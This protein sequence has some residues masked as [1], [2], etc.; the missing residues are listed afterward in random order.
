MAQ[1]N[2][3]Y[4]NGKH[5]EEKTK[6]DGSSIPPL[7]SRKG[8]TQKDPTPIE[9]GVTKPPMLRQPSYQDKLNYKA[10]LYSKPTDENNHEA[11]I[12]I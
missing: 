9:K 6:G 3:T 12:E 2:Y 8:Y 1:K 11:S 5:E 10:D 4:L 7:S